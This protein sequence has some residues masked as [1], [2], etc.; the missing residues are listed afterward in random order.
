MVSIVILLQYVFMARGCTWAQPQLQKA[1][2]G[3]FTSAK[4]SKGRQLYG[5]DGGSVG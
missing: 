5:A 3:V 2:P 4:F 1:P